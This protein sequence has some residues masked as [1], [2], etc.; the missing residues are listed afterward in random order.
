LSHTSYIEQF[1][2]P[3]IGHLPLAELTVARLSEMFT[4]IGRQTNRAGLPHT[5]STLAHVR[6]TLRAALNAAVRDGLIA[7]NPARHVELPANPRPRPVVW[8][9]ARVAAW[10]ATGARP[11]IAVWGPAMLAEFL[12]AVRDDRLFA[13]WWLLA[14]RGLRRGEAAALRWSDVDLDHSELDVHRARTTAGYQVFEGMPK[15]D[16]SRRT[17]ALDKH[18]VKVLRDHRR[19]QRATDAGTWADGGYVFT[20]PDGSPLHPDA[21]TRR[22]TRLLGCTD[23][24]PVR[25]HDLRHGAACLAHAAG[26][27][28]K[29]IQQQLGHSTI[30]VTA[31][32]Y[33]TVLPAT[34]RHS[35]KAT[36]KL[37]RKAAST[38]H[39]GTSRRQT[40]DG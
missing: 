40:R 21:I 14:L 35:A 23:L 24:P 16:A 29:T 27:D 1:L 19:R 15:T 4:R 3:H 10:Q 31:D 22:F 25:L 32:I 26:A 8:T 37:L 12:D 2:I 6:T 5:P 33:T 39:T 13:L 18:T 38:R 7:G 34:Q 9:P 11:R 30:A 36:A 28:L 20:G 17:V